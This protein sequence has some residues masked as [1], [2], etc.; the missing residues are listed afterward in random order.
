[1]AFGGMAA[2]IAVLER[3]PKEGWLLDMFGAAV[4]V[5]LLGH[6]PRQE[7]RSI[8]KQLDV[9]KSDRTIE[10][11]RR[12][13]EITAVHSQL[14]FME[15]MRDLE[16]EA[17]QRAKASVLALKRIAEAIRENPVLRAVDILRILDSTPWCGVLGSPQIR[18]L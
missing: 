16:Q 1:M 18:S 4:R 3:R 5:A 14:D 8:A 12:L 2:E 15:I 13:R 10:L 11:L 7:T 6:A 17:L 9:E